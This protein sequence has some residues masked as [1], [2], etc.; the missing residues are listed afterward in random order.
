MKLIVD[1]PEALYDR[2]NSIDYTLSNHEIV[3]RSYSAD[4]VNTFKSIKEGTVVSNDCGPCVD[5]TQE[6]KSNVIK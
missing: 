1:I 6:D 3:E 5:I 4:I 2:I